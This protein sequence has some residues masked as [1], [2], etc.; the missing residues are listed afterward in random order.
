MNS[1]NKNVEDI[2]PLSPNQLSLLFAHLRGSSDDPGQVLVRCWLE[3]N[4]DKSLFQAC[5]QWVAHRHPVLRSSIHWQDIDQPLQVVRR[6]VEFDVDYKDAFAQSDDEKQQTIQ[7]LI[8]EERSSPLR[9]NQIPT[10]RITLLSFAD[11]THFMCW[12]CHHI[13]VDGWSAGIVLTDIVRRYQ[14]TLLKNNSSTPPPRRF[15]DYITWI[16]QQDNS[17][18][19]RF[20]RNL[21]P[22][23]NTRKL[24]WKSAVGSANKG[25]RRVSSAS[26]T[27]SAAA[28]RNVTQLIRSQRTTLGL[29]VQAVWTVF[30]HKL[31]RSENIEYLVT[32]SGR[33]VELPGIDTM[34]GQ[35]SNSLPVAIHVRD[36]QRFIDVLEEVSRIGGKLREFEHITPTQIQDW[37]CSA[38]G[39]TRFNIGRD[40]RYIS[41]LVVVENFPWKTSGH[42]DHESSIR[43]VS[44]AGD[45]TSK[46]PFTL[47]VMDGVEL[48]L[49]LDVRGQVSD[50]LPRAMLEGVVGLA[51]RLFA[52]PEETIGLPST[53]DES[54]DRLNT[55]HFFRQASSSEED[56]DT[57]AGEVEYAP[58][59]DEVEL[60]LVVIWQQAFR[61]RP[62]GVHDDFFDIGGD[63]IIAISVYADIEK[64]FDIKLPL[65]TIIE[66]RTITKL[67]GLVRKPGQYRYRSLVPIQPG[68]KDSLPVF[69]I[70]AEGD[71]IF[72]KDLARALGER[73]SFYGLQAIHLDGMK[74][75]FDRVED[76]ANHYIS[77]IKDVQP[78]GPYT[79]VGM[80]FG[81]LI[82]FEMA[83]QLRAQGEQLR[84]LVVIDSVGPD[85]PLPKKVVTHLKDRRLSQVVGRRI[86]DAY[87]RKRRKV[88]GTLR[89]EKKKRLDLDSHPAKIHNTRLRD[90]YQAKRFGGRIICIRNENLSDQEMARWRE[91]ADNGVE[92]YLLPGKHGNIMEPPYVD[93]IA[94]III[95]EIS[96][97]ADPEGAIYDRG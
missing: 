13:L 83:Q 66:Y 70:H 58:P 44:L 60:Q 20:W 53:T 97:P 47:T 59:R 40:K 69:G 33:S 68:E 21:S 8:D 49:R 85:L 37:G 55:K 71:V 24:V 28:A 84:A 88:D 22:P 62:I 12:S 87:V 39:C 5:W 90:L 31:C 77:E 82:A 25:E 96:R 75:P 51:E 63:S 81:G 64:V 94:D 10:F 18:A 35:F 79:I 86:H 43:L 29:A 92:D 1:T 16:Q 91:F 2:Y 4:L 14:D 17:E 6:T 46:F 32:V 67:A 3:G 38:D 74:R 15:H 42:V 36:E 65:S 30:L 93:N 57:R 76:M 11:G 61:R 48:A 9:L 54:I 89:I 19:Q 23:R 72:Y 7:S 27:L 95:Q 73:Q 80:C 78:N 41:S 45:I 26:L 34:V 56:K 50:D 52:F